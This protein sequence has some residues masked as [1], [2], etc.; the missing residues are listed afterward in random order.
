MP[1]GRSASHEAASAETSTESRN[2]PRASFD[3]RLIDVLEPTE[4]V[5]SGFGGVEQ[6]GQALAG[7]LAPAFEDGCG[8]GG[9]Q[10]GVAGDGLHVQPAHGGGK[11]MVGDLLALGARA[12]G[13]V[14]VQT[15]VP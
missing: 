4:F 3:C 2:P 5:E 15:A 7:G 9:D 12:D 8:G 14:E 1:C 10:S 13:V 6:F 11:V